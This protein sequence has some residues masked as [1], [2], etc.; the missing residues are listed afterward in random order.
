MLGKVDSGMD[1]QV[2]NVVN[3]KI[4]KEIDSKGKLLYESKNKR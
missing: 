4:K 3:D 2:Y 1:V